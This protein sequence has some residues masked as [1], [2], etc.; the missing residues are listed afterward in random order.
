MSVDLKFKLITDVQAEYFAVT[1]ISD[2]SSDTRANWGLIVFYKQYTET[3]YSIA[4]SEDQEEWNMSEE[5]DGD[6]EILIF[7]VPLWTATSFSAGDVVYYNGVFYHTTAGATSAAVPGVSSLWIASDGDDVDIYLTKYSGT[8]YCRKYYRNNELIPQGDLIVLKTGDHAFEVTNT[9]GTDGLEYVLFDYKET[10][11]RT[12]Q[13]IGHVANLTFE[14]DGVY[15]MRTAEGGVYYV[16]AIYDFTDTDA[17]IMKIMSEIAC[18]DS[19]CEDT[20]P[21]NEK[22]VANLNLIISLY[23]MIERL[24]VLE[25]YKYSGSG[26]R[27]ATRFTYTND[28]GRL[29]KKLRLIIKK[30]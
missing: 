16:E 26:V 24:V 7:Q 27:D 28:I 25:K 2:W 4:T 21:E 6:L 13:F 15:Y 5:K 18:A 12:S 3:S 22:K 9:L 17:Y 19:N 1:D 20:S 30:M 10:Y 23:L 29:L 14:E 8:V 11:V